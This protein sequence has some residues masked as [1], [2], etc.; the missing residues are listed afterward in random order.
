LTF[1]EKILKFNKN[2]NFSGKLPKGI[3]IMNPFQNEQI[4]SITRQFYEKFYADNKSRHMIL[5]INPG[6]FGAGVTGIP[7]TDT[8]RLSAECGISIDGMATHEQSSVFVYEVIKACGGVKKFYSDFYINSVCPLGFTF[9]ND[10][11]RDVNYNYYDDVKL[12]NAVYDFIAASIAKQIKFGISTDVCFC[13]GNN[14]NA[15]YLN[16]INRNEKFFEKIVPLEHPRFI[17]QYRL[18]RMGEYVDKYIKA[19]SGHK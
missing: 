5:G 11:G 13:M 17:V 7:F 6:R 2:L 14:K 19:F 9:R 16:E 18:K 3:G 4:I 1:A 15:Y 10:K 12:Y 8:K